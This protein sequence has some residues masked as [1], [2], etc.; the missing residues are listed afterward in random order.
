MSF[1]EKKHID[2]T[3]WIFL[4]MSGL[5]LLGIFW[6]MQPDQQQRVNNYN[7]EEKWIKTATCPELLDYIKVGLEQD[8]ENSHFFIPAAKELHEWKCEK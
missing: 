6:V 2:P 7:N 4:L 3:I 8:P 5:A 1:T